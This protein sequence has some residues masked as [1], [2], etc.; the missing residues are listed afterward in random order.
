MQAEFKR[1]T[2]GYE[3]GTR[4]GVLWGARARSR[5]RTVNAMDDGEEGVRWPARSPVERRTRLSCAEVVLIESVPVS[6][7]ELRRITQAAIVAGCMP[8]SGMRRIRAGDGNGLL[9]LPKIT[10][11]ALRGDVL[12]QSVAE[13]R[14]IDPFKQGLPL[15][16][17]SRRHR[18][19][20]LVELQ[21]IRRLEEDP[22]LTCPGCNSII[23]VD[24]SELRKRLGEVDGETRT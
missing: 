9:R 3:R 6:E 11:R 2:N 22:K 5:L 13:R 24:A 8:D 12:L 15:A 19:V 20:H 4:C 7:M 21:T 1:S 16:E 18:E 23:D 10:E 14:K 17:Q